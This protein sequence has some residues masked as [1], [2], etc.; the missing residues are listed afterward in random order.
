MQIDVFTLFP[1][2]F[3]WFREQ[4]HMKNLFD[5]GH[6]LE[7]VDMRATT[8]IANNRVDDTPY[9]GGAGMV[10]RVDVVEEALRGRYGVD[11]VE[12]GS[13][14]RVV[15]LS[16]T[17]RRLDDPMTEE[18]AAAGDLTILCG[19]YEGF[20]QRVHDHFATDI[21]SI[22]DYVLSGGELA[23]M[24]LVA[25]VT[26]KL[27]E[28]HG[29]VRSAKEESFSAELDGAPEYPHYTRPEQHRGWGVPDVLLSGHHGEIE[30]WRREQSELRRKQR[31]SAN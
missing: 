16:P 18:L 23:A 27:P 30:C 13:S 20:D 25:A 10:I 12:L 26:R 8:P 14:R 4:R 3:D 15:V 2:W 9:G 29:D 22:G 5:A 31:D 28:A 17:G 19:R 24:V 6:S 21:V 7:T 11:P 1:E